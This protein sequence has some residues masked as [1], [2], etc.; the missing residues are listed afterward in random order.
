MA[1]LL[2][3]HVIVTSGNER[4]DKKERI[5]QKLLGIISKKEK[6]TTNF[7]KL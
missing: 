1:I 2:V 5:S 6:E 7:R 4:I 3:K